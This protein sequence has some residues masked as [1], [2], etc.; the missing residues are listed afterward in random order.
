MWLGLIIEISGSSAFGIE[1]TAD[2]CSTLD[3]DHN[4]VNHN[5]CG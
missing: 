2:R 3:I 5:T 1:L 4:Y